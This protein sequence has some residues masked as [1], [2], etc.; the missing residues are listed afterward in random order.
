MSP[1]I[2]PLIEKTLR[3]FWTCEFT[4]LAK[5]GT[6]I[7]WP[8]YPMYL[9]RRGQILIAS[10]I[11]YP[12]K[13]LH[14]RRNPRVSLLY[15]EP[16]GSGLTSPAR[17]LIQGLAEAPDTIHTSSDASDPEIFAEVLGQIKRVMKYQPNTT[18][19]LAN[20]FTQWLMDWY[21]MRLTILVTP[22]RIRWWEGE[23]FSLRPHDWPLKQEA[24]HVG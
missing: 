1:P 7:T 15:S 14:V 2:P 3:H 18:I 16:T 20:P 6:P 13:A 19:Y 11:G 10:P 22:I 24:E 5:D 9:A 21:F 12:Q 4:T 17:V 23:D 8:V